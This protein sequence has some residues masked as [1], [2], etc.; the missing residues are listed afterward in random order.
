[1]QAELYMKGTIFLTKIAKYMVD[2][3]VYKPSYLKKR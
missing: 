2:I 1:M 3:H